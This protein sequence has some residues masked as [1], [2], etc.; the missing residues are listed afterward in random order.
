MI[1]KQ[2]ATHTGIPSQSL[3][4]CTNA[5]MPKS[6]DLLLLFSRQKCRLLCFPVHQGWLHSPSCLRVSWRETEA[7]PTGER[8]HSEAKTHFFLAIHLL[9]SPLITVITKTRRSVFFYFNSVPLSYRGW[10]RRNA[11]RCL[12]YNVKRRNKQRGSLQI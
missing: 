4:F 12:G 3:I 5:K 6:Y 10:K 11:Q 1:V 8:M 9:L 2:I 7:L